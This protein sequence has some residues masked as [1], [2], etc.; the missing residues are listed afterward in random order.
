MTKQEEMVEQEQERIIRLLEME[1]DHHNMGVSIALGKLIDAIRGQDEGYKK[2]LG[3]ED[4]LIKR[5]A[6]LHAEIDFG[7]SGA[8]SGIDNKSPISK[9]RSAKIDHTKGHYGARMG[10]GRVK[11]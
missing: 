6:R 8:V 10:I 3:K 9:A 4:A 1:R 11:G 5:Q 7:A 2:W